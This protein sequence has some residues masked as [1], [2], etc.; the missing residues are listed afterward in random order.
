M[1][2]L[3]KKLQRFLLQEM[4]CIILIIIWSKK[5]QVKIL[6]LAKLVKLVELVK[7]LI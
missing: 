7:E 3:R 1:S 4:K 2:K 6:G 5:R